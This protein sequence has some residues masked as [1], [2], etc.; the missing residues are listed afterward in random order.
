MHFERSMSSSVV[1]IIDA[2]HPVLQ[3]TFELRE[4]SAVVAK[5]KNADNTETNETFWTRICEL[6]NIVSSNQV[7]KCSPFEIWESISYLKAALL[8]LKSKHGISVP[9][10]FLNCNDAPK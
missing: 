7:D 9:Q 1:M 6:M 5:L 2:L 10:N 4:V 3:P 8:E